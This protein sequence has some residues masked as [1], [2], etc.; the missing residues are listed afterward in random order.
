LIEEKI[1]RIVA[2]L[3]LEVKGLKEIWAQ[4]AKLRENEKEQ[5][6]KRLE[7][8][9]RKERELADFKLLLNTAHRAFEAKIIRDYVQATENKAKQTGGMSKDLENWIH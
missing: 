7:H 2:R 4:N 8:L 1:A 9:A 5:E 6:N 3:E